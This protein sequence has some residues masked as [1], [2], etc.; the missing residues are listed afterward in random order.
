MVLILDFFFGRLWGTIFTSHQNVN[1]ASLQV[2]PTSSSPPARVG[3]SDMVV[4]SKG[5]KGRGRGQCFLRYVVHAC[6]QR[7]GHL[8]L[9]VLSP[10]QLILQGAKVLILA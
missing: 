5:S 10:H 6:A 3:I 7:A 8:F 1:E 2:R 9:L 4:L